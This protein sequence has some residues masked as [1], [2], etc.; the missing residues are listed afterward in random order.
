MM[1]L[2]GSLLSRSVACERKYSMEVFTYFSSG[3]SCRIGPYFVM[4]ASM[5]A[6]VSDGDIF[7]KI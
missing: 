4:A 6:C 1:V 5:S 7:S 3:C 2:V